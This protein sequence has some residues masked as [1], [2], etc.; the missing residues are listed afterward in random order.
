[1]VR[2]KGMDDGDKET[3]CEW[4]TAKDH[5]IIF[6]KFGIILTI[7]TNSYVFRYERQSST[8]LNA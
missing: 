1:M 4:I 5:H 3:G 6:P 7:L 8:K 2:R